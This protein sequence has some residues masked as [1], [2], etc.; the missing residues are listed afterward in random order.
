MSEPSRLCSPDAFDGICA[1]HGVPVEQCWASPTPP[2]TGDS[3]LT[4][5]L[6]DLIAQA[7]NSPHGTSPEKRYDIS[8]AKAA[9]LKWRDQE[10]SAALDNQK[11]P[12]RDSS[13]AVS[14]TPKRD[15]KQYHISIERQVHILVC[16]LMDLDDSDH[17]DDAE[18][19]P[20]E[21]A[22]LTLIDQEV[23]KQFIAGRIEENEYWGKD[24]GG[25]NWREKKMCK[26]YLDR[27]A[28]LRTAAAR[29]GQEGK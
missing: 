22:I 29:L 19:K 5:I 16:T 23:Q 21:D 7:I 27:I 17:E 24:E 8:K 15:S 11:S 9:L 13:G 2:P 20:L 3:E 6:A 12:R 10:V 4:Q 18:A 26:P 14:D 1:E 25:D 28:E